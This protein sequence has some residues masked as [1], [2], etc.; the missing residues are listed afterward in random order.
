MATSE[1]INRRF[2]YKWIALI[3]TTIGALMA[4]IDV[5]AVIIALP[6]I[7]SDLQ[8]DFITVVWVLPGYMLIVAAVSASP[9]GLLTYSDEIIST[10]SVS[11]FLLWGRFC[12]DCRGYN[13]TVGV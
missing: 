12:A 10:T 9:G 8:P 5:S 2:S 11:S 13:I 1:S 7:L 4:T 3:V 6:T